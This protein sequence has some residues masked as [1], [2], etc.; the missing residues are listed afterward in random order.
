MTR[1]SVLALFFCFALGA[2]AAKAQTILDG[3]IVDS[4]T[5]T[6]GTLAT[7][8]SSNATGGITPTLIKVNQADYKDINLV[9][10]IGD[11]ACKGGDVN[12]TLGAGT[13]T[14]NLSNYPNAN[15]FKFLEVWLATGTGGCNNG[16]RHMRLPDANNCTK[17]DL[18]RR[19]GDSMS[20]TGF[21]QNIQVRLGEATCQN[22][23]PHQLYFLA[24]QS[25]NAAETA[26]YWGAIT[27][28]IDRTPPDPPTD[29]TGGMAETEIPLTWTQ[30]TEQLITY[31]TVVDTMGSLATAIDLDGGS[32]ADAGVIGASE[33]A[34]NYIQPG[35]KNFD[36]GGLGLPASLI[37]HH[38]TTKV[39]SAT[40]NGDDFHGSTLA[41]AAVIAQDLAG[42]LSPV[43]NIACL[44]VV[45]TSG[46]W[47]SYKTD[48]GEADAGCG[49]SVPGG[50]HGE[51]RPWL[52]LLGAA[53]GLIWLGSRRRARRH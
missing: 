16:D 41:A 8:P 52:S 47:D 17:L 34:S 39:G 6:A 33:C 50:A 40:F 24:L 12:G 42:N 46:F 7:S 25:S 35:Q 26:M 14:V 23:G 43:S 36:P 37:T 32:L 11:A 30:P 10:P 51:S 1:V 38:L 45:P 44:K 4:G 29:V 19:E 15:V 3:G 13:I 48:G 53:L 2:S 31:W 9:T 20:C 27:I 18:T 28:N 49:C 21:C 22:D 5:G